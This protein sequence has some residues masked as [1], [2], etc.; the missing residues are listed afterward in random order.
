M[1][2]ASKQNSFLN[3]PKTNS[4]YKN[5]SVVLFPINYSNSKSLFSTG[6][7]VIKA[8]HRLEHFDEEMSKEI[9]IEKGIC[10]LETLTVKKSSIE[11]VNQKVFAAGKILADNDKFTVSILSN[12]FL[13]EGLI[14]AGAQKYSNLSILHLDSCANCKTGNHSK[15]LD[16]SFV[17]RITAYS[18]NI[19]QVGIR[20]MSK[21]EDDFRKEK[22]IHQI[23]A[24]DIRLGILGPSWEEI[25]N[26]SLTQNV[27]IT[28]N[29]SAFDPSVFPS[30]HNPLPNGLLWNEILYLLKIIATD[31]NIVGFDVCGYQHSKYYSYLPFF[32]SKLLYKVINYKFFSSI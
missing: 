1:K 23:L 29:L 6:K 24:D 15:S 18:S 26:N 30:V 5:T 31:R 14:K 19:V 3:L 7:Q 2:E 32:I 11:K 13:D 12:N 8:S 9:C 25:V 28:L 4:T 10:T 20:S 27:Y 21:Q 17:T 16:D 22:G